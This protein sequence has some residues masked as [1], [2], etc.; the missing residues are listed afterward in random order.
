MLFFDKKNVNSFIFSI[1]K[2]THFCQISKDGANN[3]N[4]LKLIDR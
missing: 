2:Q 1:E 4:C 3:T